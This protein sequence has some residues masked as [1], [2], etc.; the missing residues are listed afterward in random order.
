MSDKIDQADGRDGENV[1]APVAIRQAR[2]TIAIQRQSTSIGKPSC[3]GCK[4]NWYSAR[5][6]L[7]GDYPER[8]EILGRPHSRCSALDAYIPIVV[9]DQ[10]KWI[11]SDIPLGCPEY[12]QQLLF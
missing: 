3:N 7:A 1:P 12:S 11:A 4:H 6:G 10:G 8:P 9:D 5:N 2:R